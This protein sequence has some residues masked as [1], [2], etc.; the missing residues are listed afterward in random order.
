MPR[1]DIEHDHSTEAIRYR[2]SQ[3]P[4]IS[5]LRDW[6]YGG[7]DGAVTT[8]AVVS[9]VVGARLSA[10]VILILGVANLFADGFSMAASNFSGTRAEL[11]EYER[12]REIERRHILEDPEG[13]RREVREIYRKKGFGG[14]DLER[15]VEVLTADRDRWIATMLREEYGLPHDVRSAQL[16]AVSTFSAFLVCGAVPLVPYVFGAPRPFVLSCVLT[17]AVFF[18][19]GA[20]RS[21]WSLAPWWRAGI[22]TFVTGGIA[23]VLAYATGWVL[24]RW[25]G[26]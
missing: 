5:Y 16:A 12:L 26:G 14:A 1:P 10:V 18:A 6:V 25:I 3:A 11:E 19:I 21:R 17:G 4:Q 7:I 15:V 24:R 13:E 20:G 8:F 23:A 9:G 2:L 22:E